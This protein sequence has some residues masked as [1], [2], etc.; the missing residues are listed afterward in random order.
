MDDANSLPTRRGRSARL[1]P[2]NRFEPLHVDPD[3]AELDKEEL[4][5][6]DT[7]YLADTTSSIL[8]KNESPDVPFTYSLNPYRGCEH[9][10]IYCYA[11]PSHEYLGFSAGLDFETKIL[12]KKDAPDLLS[13]ALQKP[14]WKSEVVSLSGNTDPYQPVERQMELSRGCLKVFLA[15]RNPVSI[16]TKSG[17]IT[18]D[19]DLLG[20]LA[21][22]N[23][24]HVT[25][26]ITS[27][28]NEVI[29]AMEPRT[30]R[31]ALRLQTVEKLSAADVPVGVM[32]APVIPGLTD[33]ELPEIIEA[34][35]HCGASTASY[36]ICR[37]PEPVDELFIDWLEH[38]FPRRKKKVLNRVRALR[39]GKL[40]DGR[41]GNR[42]HGQGKWAAMLR[43]L[44][45]VQCRRLG[46]NQAPTSLSTEHFRP[47]RGGQLDL[48]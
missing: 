31:P 27:L 32:V 38:H 45:R 29:G 17:L 21:A 2:P 48:W 46:L 13:A 20:E 34:A 8:S 43:Q 37:L 15:H 9:G 44:F 12:V 18:R 4:R 6:V 26:S 10:C 41:Y 47:L 16:I 40:T 5:Q 23:L 35:A 25:L 14:S 33:E 36:A 24:V 3:P 22:L 19:L 1:N 39:G 11:R 28:R 42:M 7:Q 30:A